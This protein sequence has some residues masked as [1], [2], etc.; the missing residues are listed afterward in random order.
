MLFLYFYLM[1]DAP[2]R[3]GAV[4]PQHAAYWRD[5]R[6][7][8]YLGGPFADRMGGLITFESGSVAEAEQLVAADPFVVEDLLDRRWL[9]EWTIDEERRDEP[10]A[11]AP[12]SR[13]P[14]DPVRTRA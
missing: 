11:R 3:V 4:A 10:I 12:G 9:R 6:L 5:L 7:T 1:R 8:D 13:R 14:V 2:D